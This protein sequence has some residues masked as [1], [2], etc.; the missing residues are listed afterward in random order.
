MSLSDISAEWY[1]NITADPVWKEEGL[2]ECANATDPKTAAPRP[3]S[4]D[5]TLQW[6]QKG[7]WCE[8]K[9]YECAD[10]SDEGDCAGKEQQEANTYVSS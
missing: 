2:A 10:R 9:F 5:L 7:D 4:G 6:A 8:G 1:R 3:C